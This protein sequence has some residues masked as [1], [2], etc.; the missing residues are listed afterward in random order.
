MSEGGEARV[1]ERRVYSAWVLVHPA[2]DVAGAWVAH[3]LDFDIVTHGESA[4]HAM[5]MVVEAVEMVLEEDM[6]EGRD[7]YARR[8][9][10]AFWEQLQFVQEHGVRLPIG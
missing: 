6:A 5:N 8:A 10:D 9:P 2:E 1:P 4:E 3:A 7:P